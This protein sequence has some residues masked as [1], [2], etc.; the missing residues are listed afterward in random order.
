[1]LNAAVRAYQELAGQVDMVEYK[2]TEPQNVARMHK[3]GVKNLP[4]I[5]INGQMRFSSIIPSNRELLDAIRE[6]MK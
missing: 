5:L 2:I 3:M 6:Y 4:S 1:M